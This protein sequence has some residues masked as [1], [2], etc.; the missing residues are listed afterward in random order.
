[1]IGEARRPSQWSRLSHR[2]LRRLGARSRLAVSVSSLAGSR[3]RGSTAVG[4]AQQAVRQEAR[5]Q[6]TTASRAPR[7][8]TPPAAATRA[9]E[10]A[11]AQEARPAMGAAV[12]ARQPRPSRRSCRRSRRRLRRRLRRRRHQRRHQRRRRHRRR[13]RLLARIVA[14]QPAPLARLPRSLGAGEARA[15]RLPHRS[16]HQPPPPRPPLHLSPPPLLPLPGP[17]RYPRRPPRR[18]PRLRAREHGPTSSTV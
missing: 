16:A 5:G 9:R 11:L 1:M 13:R 7:W 18:P 15:A 14:N 4:T 8:G 2:S 3:I 17:F 6:L 12:R 10:A